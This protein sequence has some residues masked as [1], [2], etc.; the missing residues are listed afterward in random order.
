MVSVGVV[1]TPWSAVGLVAGSVALSSTP[2]SAV[3]L[4]AGSVA[5]SST[6]DP[7]GEVGV[8]L[9]VEDTH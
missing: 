2:W 9:E 1:P 3:G 6:A 5:L 4:V 7:L 8:A